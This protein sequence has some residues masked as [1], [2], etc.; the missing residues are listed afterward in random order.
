MRIQALHW[1]RI[2]PSDTVAVRANE[3]VGLRASKAERE[4]TIAKLFKNSLLVAVGL[5][6]AL[7]GVGIANMNGFG[8]FQTDRSRPALLTSIQDLSQFHAA[9]GT[10]EVVLDETEEGLPWVPDF[11]SG[12][13]TLFVAAG[14]VNAYVDLSGLSE[15]DL[16]LSPDGKSVKV[17]L[18]EPQL[19]KPNLDQK[20]SY[21]VDQDR[22]ALDRI[23]DV[24]ELPEQSQYYQNAEAKISAAAEESELRVQAAEN[25][26]ATLTGLGRSLGVEMS[27]MD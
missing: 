1:G 25:T 27:F 23:A 16:V 19:D 12:R 26:R 22:G 11:V 13:R 18:P 20:L 6:V 17:R 21:V 14:T 10:F 5:I 4:P 15:N 8:L 2:S 7:A 24:V 3:Q 9:V